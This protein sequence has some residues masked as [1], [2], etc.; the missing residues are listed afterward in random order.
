MSLRE[1]LNMCT[2]ILLH[3]TVLVLISIFDLDEIPNNLEGLYETSVCYSLDSSGL[4]LGI[5]IF[6]LVIFKFNQML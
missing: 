2:Y 4:N 1:K 5:Y 6:N 3:N